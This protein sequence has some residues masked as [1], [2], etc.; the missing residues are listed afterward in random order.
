MPFTNTIERLGKTN[1][2]ASLVPPMGV[3]VTKRNSF[4]RSGSD[5]GFILIQLG[6]E[7]SRRLGFTGPEHGC[8]LAL[9]DGNDTGRIAVIAGGGPFTA[10]GK[11]GKAYQVTINRLSAEGLFAWD[12]PA[13]ERATLE[14]VKPE[15]G[16]P[17]CVSFAATAEM[18][19]VED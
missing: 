7:L 2:P 8:E 10:R 13:F 11:P 17:A 12:F 5:S 19:A 6:A 3:R 4:T 16:G 9:G 15:R 14:V 1:A 18:L